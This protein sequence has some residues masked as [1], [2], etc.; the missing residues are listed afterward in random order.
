MSNLLFL[1][2]YS[3]VILLFGKVLYSF[4]FLQ[5]E[6]PSILLIFIRQKVIFS[7]FPQTKSLFLRQKSHL[8]L[9][10]SDKKVLSFFFSSDKE[11]ILL[12]LRQKSPFFSSD[13]EVI[14]LFLSTR[15]LSS[16]RTLRLAF[17]FSATRL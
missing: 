8:F 16:S 10:S 9:F 1:R 7:S 5:T 14:L 2:Q 17:A 13:R 3:K 12:C 11:V 15:I 6:K 4:S